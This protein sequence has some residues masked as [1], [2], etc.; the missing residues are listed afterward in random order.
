MLWK[1]CALQYRVEE[2]EEVDKV[3][4]RAITKI[5]EERVYDKLKDQIRQ[6]KDT[7]GYG[8]E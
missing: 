8:K 2:L 6:F 7:D 3:F 5:A 4:G 1:V